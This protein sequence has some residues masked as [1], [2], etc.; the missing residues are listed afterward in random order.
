MGWN[1]ATLSKGAV[2]AATSISLA[3]LV[4]CSIYCHVPL[5]KS[6]SIDVVPNSDSRTRPSQHMRM[7]LC[8]VRAAAFGNPE[9]VCVRSE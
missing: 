5:R 7:G 2:T 1:A 4:H 8:A 6:M 9:G 3:C